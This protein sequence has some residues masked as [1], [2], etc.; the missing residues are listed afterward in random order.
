MIIYM[1]VRRWGNQLGGS[2]VRDAKLGKMPTQG[3]G[4]VEEKEGKNKEANG[5]RAFGGQ[6]LTWV[7]PS[8]RPRWR[9]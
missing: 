2:P 6:P 5:R 4:R 3:I 9:R 8:A 7:K 1:G